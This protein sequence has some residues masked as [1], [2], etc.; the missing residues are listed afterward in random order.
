M[1]KYQFSTYWK[2]EKTADVIIA[3][4]RKSLIYKKYTEDILKVPFAFD[5]PTIEQMYDFIESRCMPKERTQL[6]DYLEE[7]DLEEYNP[8]DIVKRTHGVMWEDFLWFKF[9]GEDI[10]WDEVKVRD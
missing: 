3:A 7:L 6:Q 4:D 1:H 9:P 10:S 2:D 5:N 8:W